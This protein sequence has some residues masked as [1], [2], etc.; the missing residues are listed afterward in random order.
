MEPN[1]TTGLLVYESNHKRLGPRYH[2]G[3]ALKQLE[4]LTRDAKLTCAL[5]QTTLRVAH[6]IY[7]TTHIITSL[8]RHPA[9]LGCVKT[10]LYSYSTS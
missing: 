1:C 5:T 4:R 8:D 6:S 7:T 2:S 9:F 10:L 3:T